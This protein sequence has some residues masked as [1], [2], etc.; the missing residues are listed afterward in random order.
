MQNPPC[1]AVNLLGKGYEVI[2]TFQGELM[3]ELDFEREKNVVCKHLAKFE[4]IVLST[5]SKNIVTSRMMSFA[6][7]ELVFYFLTGKR[8]RKCKQ[9]EDNEHVS[10]CI[11]NIQL[12]GKAKLIG[13]P[14]EKDNLR[15]CEIFK[16][17]HKGFFERFAHFKA[18][19]FIEVKCTEVKQWK[20]IE[21]K[22]YFIYIDL[23]KGN[24]KRQG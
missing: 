18:A 5:S 14:S 6:N 2:N 23:I 17:R 24:A 10:L 3:I 22:D 12:E 20:M 4:N 13:H 15:V 1:P 8:T 21:G 9:I 7:E 19:I 11:D 16:Y